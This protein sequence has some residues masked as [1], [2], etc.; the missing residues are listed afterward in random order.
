M[1]NVKF[2]RNQIDKFKNRRTYE[3]IT[4]MPTWVVLTFCA[5]ATV[6]CWLIGGILISSANEFRNLLQQLSPADIANEKVAFLFSVVLLAT[7]ALGALFFGLMVKAC[8]TELQQRW[9]P[10]SKAQ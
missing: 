2:I 4:E 10:K 8:S 6:E 5:T 7:L 3:S 1:S 9:F